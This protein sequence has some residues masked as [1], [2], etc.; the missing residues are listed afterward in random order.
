[1]ITWVWIL[2]VGSAVAAVWAV[3]DAVR[4]GK[5]KKAQPLP[6]PIQ[7]EDT[8]GARVPLREEPS[9]ARPLNDV[10]S[11]G[12]DSGWWQ[13]DNKSSGVS[14]PNEGTTP[15]ARV[16]MTPDGPMLLTRAPFR[17]KR[18]VMT[19][20]ERQ[21]ARALAV[22][23]PSG[24]V[25]CPQVRLDGLVSPVNP[26]GWDARDWATW[27]RRVR[28]RSVDIVICRLPEWTPVVAIEISPTEHDAR[29][30]SRDGI[31]AEVCAEV[32]LPVVRCSRTPSED[33]KLIEPYVRDEVR[34]DTS[35][36]PR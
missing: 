28:L 16:V 19:H 33:W 24:Y 8:M 3:T 29:A 25:A 12:D 30:A 23:L 34:A 26:R 21:F 27:R 5:R 14:D 32:G 6:G 36:K 7:I 17:L 11:S 13:V 4:S 22:K 2:A 18:S 20:R 9:F 31:V 15:G 1:M 35:N 10:G